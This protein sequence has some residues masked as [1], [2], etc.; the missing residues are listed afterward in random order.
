MA[1]VIKIFGSSTAHYMTIGAGLHVD[2]SDLKPIPGIADTNLNL[3][4]QRWFD[5]DRDVNWDTLIKLCD[6]FRDQLGKA[7]SNLLAYIGGLAES[8]ETGTKQESKKIDPKEPLESAAAGKDKSKS[9]DQ[10]SDPPPDVS[11]YCPKLDDIEEKILTKKFSKLTGEEKE[12]IKKV[13]Y[14]LVTATPIEYRAVMGSIKPTGDD[15]QYIKVITKDRSA[16]FILGKYESC[17]VAIT[18]TGQEPNE[19][20]DIL[21]SVQKDVEAKYVIAIGI[22]YGA[23]ES[24]TDELDDKT[25]LGDIIVAKSIIDTEQ[26]RIEGKDRSTI[27]TEYHCGTNLFNLFKHSEVFKIEKK[28]VKV[29]HQGSLASEFTLFRSKEAKEEKLKY[30][31]KA[32][33]GEMEAKGIYRAAKRG[34]GFE[35]IVI[36]AIVDWGTEEKD[37]MWQPFGAVSCARFVL[38]CLDD[39]DEP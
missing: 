32:L 8:H 2:V 6:D 35:W 13:R 5:A 4:F 16:N 22:C 21:V 39:E 18:R 29:H 15:G 23:K 20:E 28:T 25:K 10:K 3:V 7:K 12:F 34:G 38:Q 14:I 33:G 19:T 37:K 36:K 30:V 9:D 11:K 1:A 26:Q 17:N 27:P 31:Q 24:K